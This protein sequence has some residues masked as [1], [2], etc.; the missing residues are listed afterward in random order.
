MTDQ[1]GFSLRL[2][3]REAMKD[4]PDMDLSLFRQAFVGQM[5]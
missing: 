2:R 3:T 5:T 1:E 4:F